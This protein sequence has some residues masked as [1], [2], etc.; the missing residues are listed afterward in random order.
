MFRGRVMKYLPPSEWQSYTRGPEWIRF[1]RPG[2]QIFGWD[3]KVPLANTYIRQRINEMVSTRSLVERRETRSY[4]HLNCFVFGTKRA[5]STGM[6]IVPLAP[7]STHLSCND[8]SLCACTFALLST[9]DPDN[10]NEAGR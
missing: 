10:N 7:P 1:V 5:T 8:E 4:Q 6:E 2:Y 9:G 3:S